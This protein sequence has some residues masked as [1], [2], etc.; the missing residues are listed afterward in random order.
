MTFP[1]GVAPRYTR[2]AILMGFGGCFKMP[3]VN[4]G[5]SNNR[6]QICQSK[7]NRSERNCRGA[8]DL[9]FA[10]RNGEIM[11]GPKEHRKRGGFIVLEHAPTEGDTGL[12]ANYGGTV[13]IAGMIGKIVYK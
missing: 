12:A 11:A 4:I 13:Y 1:G 10:T 2:P 6:Q 3:R 7:E 8:K 9:A 5:Q